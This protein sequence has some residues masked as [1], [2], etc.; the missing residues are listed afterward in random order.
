MSTGKETLRAICPIYGLGWISTNLQI[1]ENAVL[2]FIDLEKESKELSAVGLRS[3]SYKCVLEIACDYDPKDHSTDPWLNLQSVALNIEAALR[4]Y[5]E[6]K[7]GVAAVIYYRNN[8]RQSAMI[9]DGFIPNGQEDYQIDKA[10]LEQFTA[11]F[12]EFEIA[13]RE[14]PVA[15]QYFSRAQQRFNKNDKSIDL[16]T[17]LESLF[18]PTDSRGAKK[19]FLTQGVKILG[20]SPA[21]T[22]M[23][24]DLYEFRNTIIHGD[25]NQRAAI[26]S[27]QKGNY[28]FSWFEDCERLVRSILQKYINQPWR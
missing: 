14:K 19:V 11:F 21:E 15:L 9:L 16:C 20:F 28:T 4:I 23:I 7:I 25:H 2:R 17:A 3:I 27:K 5:H 8:Q 1:Q 22:Q 13:Y 12:T 24:N 10:K 26:Y 6:G 18:V